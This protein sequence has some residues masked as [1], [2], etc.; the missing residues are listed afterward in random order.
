[1]RLKPEEDL[2]STNSA[3]EVLELRAANMKR[4]V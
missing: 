1:M 4:K 2:Q 3:G